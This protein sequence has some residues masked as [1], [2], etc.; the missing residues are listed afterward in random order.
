MYVWPDW[1]I[2]RLTLAESMV[3]HPSPPLRFLALKSNFKRTRFAPR[4][5]R[6]AKRKWNLAIG[7]RNQ[8]R[9]NGS[10][11]RAAGKAGDDAKIF[12]KFTTGVHNQDS[13]ISL[14]RLVGLEIGQRDIGRAEE[15]LCLSVSS[16][17]L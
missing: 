5:S 16:T 14:N 9:N 15:T 13:G 8:L 6:A 4:G 11:F 7:Q 2:R 17:S 10:S 3:S 12:A 1:R